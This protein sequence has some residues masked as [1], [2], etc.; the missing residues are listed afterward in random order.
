MFLYL[1]LL[2]IIIIFATIAVHEVGHVLLAKYFGCSGGKA[3]IL[4][5]NIGFPY[6]EFTC[7]TRIGETA[8][9]FGGLIFTTVLAMLL[10]LVKEDERNL[11]LF[12]LGF[13][14]VGAAEDIIYLSN[15]PY[16]MYLFIVIG[17]LITVLGIHKFSVE[18]LAHREHEALLRAHIK[19]TSK[20]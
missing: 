9:V 6:A 10:S 12:V 14:F 16:L 18:Y 4:D 2:L 13:G 1:I 3:V 7:P 15:N 19:S 20:K 17:T 8:A 5:L 11:S